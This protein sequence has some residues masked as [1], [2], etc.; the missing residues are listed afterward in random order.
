ME[1]TLRIQEN[2]APKNY[3]NTLTLYGDR[4]IKQ[5]AKIDYLPSFSGN[6]STNT[7]NCIICNTEH[8]TQWSFNPAFKGRITLSCRNSKPNQYP[9]ITTTKEVTNILSEEKKTPPTPKNTAHS[10][11]PSNKNPPKMLETGQTGTQRINNLNFI[12][13][14]MDNRPTTFPALINFLTENQIDIAC[15]Q[16]AQGLNPLYAPL[17]KYGYKIYSH[18]K[19][20]IIVHRD[21]TTKIISTS[22]TWTSK[23]YNSMAITL[24]TTRGP[25]AIGC[26]Y[27]PSDVDNMSKEGKKRIIEQHLELNAHLGQHPMA[28][29]CMDANET[30]H[31]LGRIN[32]PIHDDTQEM[33]IPTTTTKLI[34]KSCENNTL[35]MSTMA[36]YTKTMK[37]YPITPEDNTPPTY[38]HQQ[39]AKGKQNRTLSAID[40][41][42]ISK[43]LSPSIEKFTTTDITRNWAKTPTP[44]FHC[45]IQCTITWENLWKGRTPTTDTEKDPLKGEW[46]E[47]GPNMSNLDDT[48]AAQISLAVENELEKYKDTIRG[49]YENRTTTPA[50]KRDTLHKLYNKIHIEQAKRFLGTK[51]AARSGQYSTTT[52]TIDTWQ[53][54]HHQIYKE[55]QK[56]EDLINNKHSTNPSHE[57]DLILNNL[58]NNLSPEINY[59]TDQHIHIPIQ[60]GWY[61]LLKWCRAKDY[62]MGQIRHIKETCKMTD[63]MAINNPKKLT[64]QICKPHG[65]TH[66][67]SLRKGNTLLTT[68]KDI[69]HELTEYLSKI[70]GTEEKLQSN[71]TIRNEH[72]NKGQINQHLKYILNSTV[73]PEELRDT[74]RDLDAGA[75]A[76]I[77]P[78][79]LIKITTTTP[80][81]TEKRSKNTPRTKTRNT[82]T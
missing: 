1:A 69:E 61:P 27:L 30:I 22:E 9:T 80:W 78:I 79:Q 63:E 26:A 48:K 24:N 74:I 37:V 14:N 39:T 65:T 16:E 5:I 7:G 47:L 66:I 35:E 55:L 82:L 53:R 60:E 77:L 38:T 68:D 56:M 15:L 31:P 40:Y 72:P 17:E 59:L 4:P 6:I 73:S 18:E 10:K 43:N 21:T 44:S 2:L 41:T 36:C 33:T 46:I 51:K 25:L 13:W 12:N 71:T 23:L 54:V 32:T 50:N 57:K 64:R 70:A 76:G 45:L 8:L 58:A 11:P 34:S 67:S 52:E 62:H 42:L 20:A 19:V 28:I 3:K 75:G 29:L 49:T 81:E